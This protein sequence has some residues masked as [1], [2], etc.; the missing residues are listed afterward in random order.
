MTISLNNI[1][2]N[3]KETLSAETVSK[4]PKE[5]WIEVMDSRNQKI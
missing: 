4:P 2:F 3:R 5:T 1:D